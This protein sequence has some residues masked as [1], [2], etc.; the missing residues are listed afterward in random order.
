MS[1]SSSRRLLATV[2]CLAMAF[3]APVAALAE[4]TDGAVAANDGVTDGSAYDASGSADYTYGTDTSGTS[5][6]AY[7]PY[8]M[9][10]DATVP[11]VTD[12]SQPTG[13]LSAPAADDV[14][15]V[16]D[17]EPVAVGVDEETVPA[18]A[19][20]TTE[21]PVA[22][23]PDL[24]TQADTPALDCDFVESCER[25]LAKWPVGVQKTEWASMYWIG[26]NPEKYEGG[27]WGESTWCSEFVGWNLWNVG[28]QPGVNMPWRPWKSQEYYD[29]YRAHP[30]LAEIHE[31]NGTYS[32]RKGDI[33]LTKGLSHTEMVSSVTAGGMS[34]IGVEGGTELLRTRRELSNDTYQ[35]FITIKWS[36][37]NVPHPVDYSVPMSATTVSALSDFTWTG[38]AITPKPTVKYG[39]TTLVKD[40]DYTLSYAN[41][42]NP[43]TARVTITGKGDSFYGSK[44]LSYTIVKPAVEEPVV[45]YRTHVQRYGW[46]KY[47]S[48]GTLSGTVGKGKRLEGIRIKLSNTSYDG[49]IQYR[50]HVQ[51]KGWEKSWKSNGK[52]SGTVGKS[53]RLEAI[54]IRLTGTMAEQYDVYYRVH[55]QHYGWMGWAKNGAK[56]G[57]AGYGYRLE[58]IQVVLVSKGQ[59]KPTP[60]YGGVRQN[61]SAAFKQK[62]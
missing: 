7:D 52:T 4:A 5:T 28:L 36:K 49:G 51:G 46:R 50:T 23:E 29:F 12:V 53:R 62:R 6:Y 42:V 47:V 61:V 33:V 41:N 8:D 37:V 54:Q 1:Q 38:R 39:N 3:D 34:W 15:V 32:P 24:Q 18:D 48:N 55:A 22:A 16:A 27:H 43:G 26:P 9:T 45:S 19:A 59:S 17:D 58:A 14:V 10:G 31:N 60:T 57:T 20:S 35:W 40:V 2:L 11:E 13:D 30:E 21:V 56:A 44:T 25:E